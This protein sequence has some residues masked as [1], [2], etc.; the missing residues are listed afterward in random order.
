MLRVKVKRGAQWVTG[1]CCRVCISVGA[2]FAEGD[3]FRL[4]MEWL[5]KYFTECHVVLADTLQRHNLP[6]YLSEEDRE[7]AVRI[8]GD[9]WLAHNLSVVRAAGT[10]TEFSRWNDWLFHPDFDHYRQQIQELYLAGGEFRSAVHRDIN[11]FLA[12]RYSWHELGDIAYSRCC[13]YVLEEVAFVALIETKLPSVEVYP[14]SQ[15]AAVKV[16]RQTEIEGAPASLAKVRFVELRFSPL[17]NSSAQDI[18]H[19]LIAT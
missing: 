8:A 18:Q 19:G 11:S 7:K 17:G 4:V 1:G 10:R 14:G 15:L 9:A 3:N 5:R 6:S 13:R 12:R 16:F 2:P